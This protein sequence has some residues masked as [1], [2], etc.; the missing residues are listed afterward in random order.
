[1][2]SAKGNRIILNN[3]LYYRF[4]KHLFDIVFSM[5]SPILPMPR[6]RIISPVI[7]KSDEGSCPFTLLC[8]EIHMKENSN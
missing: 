4:V 2:G 8:S 1:M 5:V 6:K 3:I 7:Q